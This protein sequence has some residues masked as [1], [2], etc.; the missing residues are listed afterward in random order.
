MG[1]SFV[2]VQKVLGMAVADAHV[3]DQHSD[4]EASGLF[5]DL[6]VDLVTA[7]EVHIDHTHLHTVFIA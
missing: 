7:G 5:A 3:V 6:I 1:I 2:A 4:I